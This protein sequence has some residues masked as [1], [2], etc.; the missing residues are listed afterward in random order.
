MT[1][2]PTAA[3]ATA[4]APE[5]Y[6]EYLQGAYQLGWLI[7]PSYEAELA[8]RTADEQAYAQLCD[9]AFEAAREAARALWDTLYS[10]PALNGGRR[11]FS[12][13]WMRLALA[14]DAAATAAAERTKS[15]T[16]IDQTDNNVYALGGSSRAFYRQEVKSVLAEL[17]RYVAGEIERP[18]YAESVLAGTHRRATTLKKAPAPAKPYTLRRSSRLATLR[19]SRRIA[20]LAQ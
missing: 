6:K 12:L 10:S 19:R 15:P 16:V 5:I 1:S 7:R 4:I 8:L 2:Q 3:V 9:K 14:K 17:E 11:I 18:H 13:S 20:A